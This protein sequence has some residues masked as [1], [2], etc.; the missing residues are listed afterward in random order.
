MWKRSDPW[1]A[2]NCSDI[3]KHRSNPVKKYVTRLSDSGC[4]VIEIRGAMHI[5]F[6]SLSKTGDSPASSPVLPETTESA[7]KQ[8]M[9][10][11]AL[12]HRE[13]ENSQGKTDALVETAETSD[14]T[15]GAEDENA[16]VAS[17]KLG[18][19][20]PEQEVAGSVPAGAESDIPENIQ[21]GLA[22]PAGQA[23]PDSKLTELTSTG[24]QAD[25]RD[26]SEAP[27]EML[28]NASG[29]RVRIAADAASPSSQR[30]VNTADLV[31]SDQRVSEGSETLLRSSDQM[32]I[33]EADFEQNSTTTQDSRNNSGLIP[34]SALTTVPSSAATDLPGTT[35]ETR[36]KTLT[37]P[38]S[39]TSL[40]GAQADE[41][42]AGSVN[43]DRSG[44]AIAPELASPAPQ[45]GP[46]GA[47]EKAL[48]A[49]DP[50]SITRRP[51]MAE[52]VMAA[53]VAA[54]QSD[55]DP[56]AQFKGSKAENSELASA[57]A[58]ASG[59]PRAGGEPVASGL[60]LPMRQTAT[61]EPG[62]RAIG[63]HLG[64]PDSDVSLGDA[65]QPG[66]DALAGSAIR[67]D[68]VAPQT[69]STNTDLGFQRSDSVRNAAAQAV[70]VF[71][72]QPG[73]PV[74]ISL[75]PQ[76][77]GRVRMALTTSETGVTVVIQSE[78]PETLDLMRRHIDQLAQEFQ[79]LG[80]ENTSFQFGNGDSGADR[81][82]EESTDSTCIMSEE[83]DSNPNP[84]PTR[85]VSTGLDLR[86]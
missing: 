43:S 9:S 21:S 65:M 27:Q 8:G 74:E 40:G 51:M 61:A 36:E 66:R 16:D 5:N 56:A 4:N 80:Y 24:P 59:A 44:K 64:L 31:R 84:T 42:S 86:L 2:S 1:I 52:T 69:W 67:I 71:V 39:T 76:E 14:V 50:A 46:P 68:P 78:R 20:E 17:K 55:V 30:S 54:A 37:L 38:T 63:T 47:K 22:V 81:T 79:Q 75:N 18:E 19:A 72:R 11:G 83:T 3:S 15:E 82:A 57:T 25:F 48:A 60:V 28:E 32:Q 73:K 29:D 58:L 85:L 49:A 45:E 70:E 23:E 12:F 34:G 13:S 26:S 6:L 10:F 53:R 7:A 33:V 41:Q 35:P 62:A 77:L